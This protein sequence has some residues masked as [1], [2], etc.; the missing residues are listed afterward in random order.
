M[1]KLVSVSFWGLSFYQFRNSTSDINLQKSKRNSWNH[2]LSVSKKIEPGK[3][4]NLIRGLPSWDTTVYLN[5]Q[6]LGLSLYLLGSKG[7]RQLHISGCAIPSTPDCL[8]FSG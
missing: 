4:Y 1:E 8:V 5:V 6:C 7:L 2:V 3:N